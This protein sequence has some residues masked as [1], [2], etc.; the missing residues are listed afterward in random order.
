MFYLFY[1]LQVD[2]SLKWNDVKTIEIQVDIETVLD[3]L[4]F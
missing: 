2:E 1:N 3:V 4:V